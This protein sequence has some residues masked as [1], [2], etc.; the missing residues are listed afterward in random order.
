MPRRTSLAIALAACAFALVPG[1]DTTIELQLT[2]AGDFRPSDGRS[3]PVPHWHIDQAVAS[4]VIARFAARKNPAV[5][6]Y[7]HQTL[8]KETNGQPAPAAAWIKGLVWHEGR[9]LFGTVELTARARQAINDGEYL[10]VSPVFTYDR[11]TGDVLDIQM[12]AITN[13]AAIDGMEPLALRA[14][15]TFGINLDEEP[16]MNKLL[17]AVCTALALAAT[18]TEDQAVEALNTHFKTDPLADIRKA[19]G[20][21]P[22]DKPEALVAACTALK[23]KAEASSAEPDPAK[24]V[25]VSVLESVKTDLAALTAKVQ[26]ADVDALV[27]AGLEDGRLLKAQEDWARKLGKS[28]IAAL[29]AYLD[30]AAPIAALNNSQTHGKQPIVDEA[31][32]LNAEQLAVCSAT[33]IDP[34]DFAAAAKAA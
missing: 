30:S 32:G 1:A 14:A 19:L 33:G 6:D 10:F 7:E 26:G 17:L 4:K 13:T 28:D 23:T 24:Y 9:G 12:A 34:K 15:A 21:D 20:A 2:P 11:Q 5:V 8:H 18:T 25:P 16:S 27:S 29:T 22:K 31:N 3:I